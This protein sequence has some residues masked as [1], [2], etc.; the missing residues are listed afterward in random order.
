MD[1]DHCRIALQISSNP[2]NNAPLSDLTIMLGA[3]NTVH[4]ESLISQPEGGIWEAS[5][6]SVLWCVSE[7]N[8]GEKFQLQARFALREGAS[9]DVSHFPVLVRCQS[10]PA[11]LSDV[12]LEA[13]GE[14]AIATKIAKRFRLSHREKN[15]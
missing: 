1:G 2:N 13:R 15:G 10:L 8:S 14:Q 5:K 3:P 11:Q 6:S 12:V 9:V 4:G 7:L